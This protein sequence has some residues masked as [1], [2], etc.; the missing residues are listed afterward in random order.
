MAH[1]PR[2]PFVEF[3]DGFTKKLRQQLMAFEN[4]I[5]CYV[6]L[7]QKLI[8]MSRTPTVARKLLIQRETH[9]PL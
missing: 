6:S 3:L 1:A 7:Q 9:A 2:T 8:A 4:K 5:H